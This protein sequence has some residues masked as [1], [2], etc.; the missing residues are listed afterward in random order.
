MGEVRVF[1]DGS[2]PS[3][4]LPEPRSVPTP[5]PDATEAHSCRASGGRR[6]LGESNPALRLSGRDAF[7]VHTRGEG[8]AKLTRPR[9][10]STRDSTKC[11]LKKVNTEP[12][13]GTK[14][15]VVPPR[16]K[17]LVKRE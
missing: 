9:R 1:D 6:R 17:H 7:P 8:P 16:V 13:A 10:M 11:L 14:M 5:L 15:P 3:Y 2:T 4:S 12:F